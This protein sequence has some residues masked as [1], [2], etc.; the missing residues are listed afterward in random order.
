MHQLKLTRLSPLI[1]ALLISFLAGCS[2]SPSSREAQQLAEQLI[3]PCQY[4]SIRPFT[5]VN[6][7]PQGEGYYQVET[8]FTLNFESGKLYQEAVES[9]NQQLAD[10]DAKLQTLKTQKQETESKYGFELADVEKRWKE[11]SGTQYEN[12]YLGSELEALGLNND[13]IK[14]YNIAREY[15]ANY[16]HNILLNG[17]NGLLV[18]RM[19]D[20]LSERCPQLNRSIARD[21][22]PGLGSTMAEIYKFNAFDAASYSTNQ[23]FE[24][25][26][27]LNMMKTDNGWQGAR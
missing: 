17:R 10:G 11:K 23:R 22:F 13:E 20:N 7:I 21:M 14:A 12:D 1:G 27:K 16:D 26:W 2:N 25:H 8:K 3:G 6:G 5:K 24:Y 15:V 4:L 18:S 19:Y 9:F